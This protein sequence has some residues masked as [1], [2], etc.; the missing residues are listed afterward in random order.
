MPHSTTTTQSSPSLRSE[1]LRNPFFGKTHEEAFSR[2]LFLAE[3]RLRLGLLFGKTGTGKTLLM[4][5]FRKELRERGE[6]SAL[7]NLRGCSP[8]EFL[9]E[10]LTVFDAPSDRPWQPARDWPLLIEKMRQVE[11][12]STPAVLLLDDLHLA[13]PP[14]RDEIVRL[15]QWHDCS[16]IRR[17]LVIASDR[18]FLSEMPGPLKARVD[19]PIELK[20]WT[21][22]ETQFHLQQMGPHFLRYGPVLTPDAIRRI[23]HWSGGNPRQICEMVH[24][25]VEEGRRHGRK[26]VPASLV[27]R[28]R[29]AL[30]ADLP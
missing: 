29:A 5:Q 2:L 16:G 18:S 24:R 17:T 6:R 14:V 1:L 19:L 12:G 15:M 3:G 8:E 23:F 4:Q 13:E 7:V 25:A 11:K 30:T 27:D 20:G 28:V 26:Y 21:L 9:S 22:Q 10:L